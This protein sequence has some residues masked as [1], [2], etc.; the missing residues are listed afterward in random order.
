MYAFFLFMCLY[1]EIQKEAQAEMDRV[2]GKGNLPTFNDRHNLPYLEALTKEI[3]RFHIIGPG[4]E[5]TTKLVTRSA[6]LTR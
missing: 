4:G 5:Q 1:P 2:V 6:Y 3:M